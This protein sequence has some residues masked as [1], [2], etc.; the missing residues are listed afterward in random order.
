[1]QNSFVQCTSLYNVHRFCTLY[2]YVMEGKYV[3]T[4]WLRKIFF[5]VMLRIF[6]NLLKIQV[7]KLLIQKNQKNTSWRGEGGRGFHVL[8]NSVC[9]AG[10]GR[11]VPKTL[12]MRQAVRHDWLSSLPWATGTNEEILCTLRKKVFF[13]GPTIEQPRQDKN[14]L[15]RH[16]EP[17]EPAKE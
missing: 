2:E 8:G 4:F 15:Y 7:L 14:L 9:S 3:G 1:M 12:I 17:N 10:Q 13:T 5:F 11:I 6:P 16:N